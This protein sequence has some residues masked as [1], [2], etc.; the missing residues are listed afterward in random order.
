ME[1]FLAVLSQLY[2]QEGK[3][4]LQEIIVNATWR[5]GDETEFDN[6]NGGM[7]GYNVFLSV[8]S[9]VYLP[10]LRNVADVGSQMTRDLNQL[11]TIERE[12]FAGVHIEMLPADTDNWRATSGLLLDGTR[13]VAPDAET[14]IW[15]DGY[16][17]F[18]SH[19]TEVKVETAKLKEELA[20]FGATCFVAHEDIHPTKDW[21]DEIENALASCDAFVAL[22]SKDFHESNWTD[23]EVGYA[24][25]RGIPIIAVRLGRDPY[26]FIGKFQALRSDWDAAPLDIAK[27]L[28]K[29]DRMV[30]AYIQQIARS[31][32]FID[33]N[34]LADLLPSIDKL[35]PATIDGIVEAYNGNLEAYGSF[36]LRGGK[37][38]YEGLVHHLNRIL[39]GKVYEIGD[40]RH[41]IQKIVAR[42]RRAPR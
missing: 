10:I 25:A 37:Y 1:H 34:K 27:L 20:K 11:N 39:G 24:V 8:P 28:I 15:G 38:G 21:Q 36:G 35:S 33:S 40:D 5:I 26:G 29:E 6:W 16:R 31:R 2:A 3:R 7:T 13:V 19:K 42:P 17:V 23:Q 9:S 32:N 12:Y 4:E 14:R 41:T 22:L 30:A 18:L